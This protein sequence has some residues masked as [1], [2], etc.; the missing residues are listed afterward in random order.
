MIR[1][2]EFASLPLSQCNIKTIIDADASLG[3]DRIRSPQ[4]R[5]VGMELWLAGQNVC[6]ENRSLNWSNDPS[7]LRSSQGMG[8]FDRETSGASSSWICCL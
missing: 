4:Q 5:D 6:Q 1:R 2:H 7:P 8:D 3:S